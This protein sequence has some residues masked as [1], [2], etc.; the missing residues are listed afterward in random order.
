MENLEAA[1]QCALSSS[2]NTEMKAQATQYCEQVKNSPDGWQLC[3]NLFIKNPPSVP[4][5]RHFAL[6][7][8]EETIRNRFNTIDKTQQDLI[9]QTLWEWVKT[10]LDSNEKPFIKNKLA[11]AIVQL[12]KNQYPENW[13]TFF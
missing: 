7:V 11:Q 5:V 1:V 2:T 8:V 9:K 13:P 12:F 3:L 10:S 6:Q 4:E